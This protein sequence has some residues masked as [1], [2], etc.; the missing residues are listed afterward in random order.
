MDYWWRW[1]FYFKAF[2]D[3]QPGDV[4]I[5]NADDFSGCGG[6][7]DWDITSVQFR[8]EAWGEPFVCFDRIQLI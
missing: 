6:M 1:V 8:N 5:T 7:S 4:V 3:G 2:Q